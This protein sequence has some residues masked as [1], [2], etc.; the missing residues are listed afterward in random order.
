[1]LKIYLDFYTEDLITFP[2]DKGPEPEGTTFVDR[3]GLSSRPE[4]VAVCRLL[5]VRSEIST[6]P[7]VKYLFIREV[8]RM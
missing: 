4:H 2:L 5:L 3:E 1:M 8:R 7:D 6:S